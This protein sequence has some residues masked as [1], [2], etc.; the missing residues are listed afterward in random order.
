M[1]TGNKTGGISIFGHE[2]IKPTKLDIDGFNDDIS[3]HYLWI[4]CQNVGPVAICT[5]YF[6]NQSNKDS[7]THSF[8]FEL[9]LR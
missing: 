2:S 8:N 3:N 4:L 1:Q 7:N 6:K 5:V 9:S